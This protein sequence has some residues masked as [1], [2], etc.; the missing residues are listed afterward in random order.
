MLPLKL[1][2]RR[3]CRP[4]SE[5]SNRP[6]PCWVGTTPAGPCNI[7][8]GPAAAHR[9]GR[10]PV[11]WRLHSRLGAA[12]AEN[13]AR[14]VHRPVPRPA[15]PPAAPRQK[16]PCGACRQGASG[17]GGRGKIPARHKLAKCLLL[18]PAHRVGV[19]RKNPGDTASAGFAAAPCR[20]CGCRGQG[21]WRRWSGIPPAR[22]PPPCPAD[23]GGDACQSGTLNRNHPPKYT[24]PVFRAA[25]ASSCARRVAGIVTPVGK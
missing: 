12:S 2:L 17:P 20:Q 4:L 7:H 13:A 15:G 1:P 18:K 16:F 11:P 19:G 9:A 3:G 6:L 5:L 8:S 10:R 21:F 24:A 14:C 22:P 23:R 25:Q